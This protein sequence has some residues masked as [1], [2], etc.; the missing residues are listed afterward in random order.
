ML[1]STDVGKRV[2]ITKDCRE[3]EPATGKYGIY[4][5]DFP[6]TAMFMVG[7]EL[8]EA[9]LDA[10]QKAPFFHLFNH[11]E[12]GQPRPPDPWWI[13]L[14]NPRIR[15]EDGSTIWGAE[16]WWSL[17]GDDDPPMEVL[18]Q[19]LKDTVDAISAILDALPEPPEP[20]P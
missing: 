15:L 1:A 10:F 17:I 3:G 14:T 19:G 2:R 13:E 5:G 6:F 20:Q 7:G 8:R 12:H 18:E 4:E 11:W 9:D 16:C